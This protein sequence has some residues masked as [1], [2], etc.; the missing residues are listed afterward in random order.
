MP[1]SR[2]GRA[3]GSTDT[4]DLT[5][6]TRADEPELM[7]ESSSV[8]VGEN[9]ASMPRGAGVTGVTGDISLGCCVCSAGRL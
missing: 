3:V 5:G 7:T 9:P 8:D 6:K 1:S 4:T 2:L